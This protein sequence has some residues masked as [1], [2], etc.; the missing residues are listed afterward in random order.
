MEKADIGFNG[1]RMMEAGG[2]E[3][4][5]RADGLPL[6]AF[7]Y[8]EPGDMRRDSGNNIDLS[9]FHQVD[10]SRRLTLAGVM[11][12]LD[13]LKSAGNPYPAGPGDPAIQGH[14]TW[15]PYVEV[16]HASQYPT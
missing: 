1:L 6:P 2:I 10:P 14:M 11:P 7:F 12:D 3:I 9:I 16:S 5:W 13:L 4:H 8:L 15:A